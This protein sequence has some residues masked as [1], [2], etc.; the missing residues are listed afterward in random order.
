M[1]TIEWDGVRSRVTPTASLE[2]R[3]SWSG[4]VTLEEHNGYWAA[5]DPETGI[6]GSGPDVLSAVQDLQQALQ[7]H[8]DVLG[9]QEALSDDLAA[10]L[11]YLC[12]R[13]S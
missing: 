7:E 10:Q 2:I 13:L 3:T 4:E 6:F 9:R 5:A 1:A 12:R 11:D 8:L